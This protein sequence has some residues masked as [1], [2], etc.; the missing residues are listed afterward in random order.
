MFI[1][2]GA[3]VVVAN[4]AQTRS[5]FSSVAT[6]GRGAE[7]SRPFPEKRDAV[8]SLRG[9]PAFLGRKMVLVLAIGDFH[10]P[11]R[12]P[13]LAQRF[14]TLLMPGKIQFVLCTGNLCSAEVDQY[15]RSISPDVHIVTGDMDS[16]PYPAKAVVNVGSLGFGICH[17]H[18]IMPSGTTSGIESLRREM[19][20]DVLITGH[21]HKL[22]VWQGKEGGLYVNPGSATGAY[23]TTKTEVEPPSFVLMDVQGSKVV[24]YSYVL[25]GEVCCPVILCSF[26]FRFLLVLDGE[27]TLPSVYS[28]IKTGR[29]ACRKRSV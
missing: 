25:D 28:C 3:E 13:T 22:A 7:L 6:A 4:T 10:I 2:L 17:G 15:L 18:Q 24:T 14:K 16:A 9:E 26:P 5:S 8:Q 21:T 19:G 11:Y 20:V 27:L 1:D 29:S 23:S 12:S